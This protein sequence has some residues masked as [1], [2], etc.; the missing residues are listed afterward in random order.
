MDRCDGSIS[1]VS[2]CVKRCLGFLTP[3]SLAT[4]WASNGV[5]PVIVCPQKVGAS[6]TFKIEFDLKACV[7]EMME[8]VFDYLMRDFIF[9]FVLILCFYVFSYFN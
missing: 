6:V 1:W 9:F 3:V 5:W 8:I 7:I 4:T 2:I